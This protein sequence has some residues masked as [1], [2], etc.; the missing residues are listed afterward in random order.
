MLKQK[1]PKVTILMCTYNGEKYIED[2]LDS[3]QCQ[4]YKNWSLIV[5]DDGSVDKTLKILNQYQKKWGIKKIQIIKGPQKGFSENFISLIK[6]KKIQG[7]YFFLSDQDDIWMPKK[8]ENYVSVFNK[9]NNKKPILIGGSSL[10]VNSDLALIGESHDFT[11][12]PTFSN[13][14][15]QSMFGGNTIAFDRNFKFQVEDIILNNISSYDWFLYI[16]NTFTGGN[17]FFLQEANI[18]Y[19]QHSNSLVGGNRGIFNIIKRFILF[20]NNFFRDQIS[21]NINNII[22]IK[23]VPL[24]NRRLLKEFILLRNGNFFD[25]ILIFFK[26]KFIRHRNFGYLVILFGSIHKKI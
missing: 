13:A 21:M 10:Y 26:N 15:V 23:R 25:R 16:L 11:H 5:S 3:F 19:R 6:N 8:I 17:T 2:Q 1:S 14:L 7:E 20:K 22:N 18:F 4:T 9:V 24:S 12:K